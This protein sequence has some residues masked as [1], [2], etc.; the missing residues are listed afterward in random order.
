M[1][2]TYGKIQWSPFTQQPTHIFLYT[3]FF[4]ICHALNV[5]FHLNKVCS[6]D[7]C[8]LLLFFCF[9]FFSF[10]EVSVQSSLRIAWCLMISECDFLNP[11]MLGFSFLILVLCLKGK[12]GHLAV[13]FHLIS[14]HIRRL[15]D[16]AFAFC[17]CWVIKIQLCFF[18]TWNFKNE[19]SKLFF[20][21]W[22]IFIIVGINC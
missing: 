20:L 15:E 22:L 16:C 9:C 8:F 5:G 18:L 3:N 12:R 19:Q 14:L 13:T 1:N 6:K 21:W 2:N 7:C 10:C 17:L 11:L 4:F